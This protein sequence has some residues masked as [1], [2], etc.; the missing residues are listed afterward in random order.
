M[1]YCFIQIQIEKNVFD[2]VMGIIF[3]FPLK[4]WFRIFIAISASHDIIGACD[5]E[6]TASAIHSKITIF[7]V[8][9]L[10]SCVVP[11]CVA[12][13]IGACDFEQTAIH[14]KITIFRVL[15]LQSCVVP[16]CVAIQLLGGGGTALH[17]VPSLPVS[18]VL[19]GYTKLLCVY[20]I[21]AA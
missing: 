3:N 15:L 17:V 1:F 14:N 9:L 10:Q 12:N 20:H 5:F 7:R 8:P 19:R 2:M 13:I 4:F 21:T 18:E 6:Q 11:P 16:P